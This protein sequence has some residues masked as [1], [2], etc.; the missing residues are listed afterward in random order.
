MLVILVRIVQQ[1][2]SEIDVFLFFQVG[3]GFLLEPDQKLAGPV[4][5]QARSVS[6]SHVPSRLL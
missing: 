2:V 5:A 1:L 3:Q 6:Y 4:K